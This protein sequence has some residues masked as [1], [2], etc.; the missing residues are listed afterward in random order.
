MPISRSNDI[1]EY[2]RTYPALFKVSY[3]LAIA[4]W[5][6]L[7]MAY[8]V[9]FGSHIWLW[10]LF[11][12]AILA[13][14]SASILSKWIN[15]SYKKFDLAYHQRLQKIWYSNKQFPSVDI[16][17]PIAGEPLDVLINT[18]KGVYAMVQKYPGKAQ[19][20]ILDDKGHDDIKDISITAGFKYLSRPNKGELKKAGNLK[21]A[22][23]RTK[24]E[25]IVIL[26]ADFKPEPDFL[27]ELMPYFLSENTRDDG[28]TLGIVQ[29]PQC[30]LLDNELAKRVPLAYGAASIQDYFYKFI[31]PSRQAFGNAAICVG[32]NAIYR[33][34]A[35]STI[36]G[37]VQVE[38]SEDV[39]TGFKLAEIGWRLKYVPVCVAYGD[40]PENAHAFYKQQSRWCAGSMSLMTSKDFWKSRLPIKTKLGFISG[41]LFY[42]SNLGYLFIPFITVASILTNQYGIDKW[43]YWYIALM[44][45]NSV[46]LLSIHIYPRWRIST[47]I[48]HMIASW[49][50]SF[51][52]V[53]LL[54]K[55]HEPWVATGV[56]SSLSPNFVLMRRIV[57]AYILLVIVSFG[58]AMWHLGSDALKPINSAYYIWI[59]ITLL[60]HSL[61]LFGLY[62]YAR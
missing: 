10:L 54:L 18:W 55:R 40:C 16:F 23:E 36:G 41:F 57:I 22:F 17:L 19:V 50:Y 20:Y 12:P 51:T 45:S 11:A 3:L 53:N 34:A 61:A 43:Y 29:S 58:F 49:S 37:T 42:L 46:I 4:S 7:A 60:S 31:Q 8:S 48:A 15:L 56:K 39:W 5:L 28:D 9:I 25:F 24:G 21:Y 38:H 27:E 13:I 26:D 1:F 35:L 44:L 52:L 2:T 6:V 14:I 47:V 33:R 30:F 62:K 32:S 59:V